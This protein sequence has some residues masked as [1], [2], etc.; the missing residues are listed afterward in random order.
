[1]KHRIQPRTLSGLKN[2]ESSIQNGAQPAGA[3]VVAIAS[4]GFTTQNKRESRLAARER[5]EHREP[6][7]AKVHGGQRSVRPTTSEAGA[8]GKRW[9]GKWAKL[10]KGDRMVGKR[11]G[12][13]HLETALTR[14]F[15]DVSTQ[16]VA[17]P[18][19]SQLSVFWL[20]VE[21]GGGQWTVDNWQWIANRGN[22][23]NRTNGTNL[24]TER[25]LMF[26]FFEK[27]YFSPALWSSP[28]DPQR[29]GV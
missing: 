12:F 4:T 8:G 23:S 13:S 7:V 11:T 25:S 17:F 2:I 29:M 27:K 6:G 3:N 1:M 9:V 19:L 14:L 26:A 5:K 18:L 28:A 24:E 10:G 16:V 21:R 15:P 22:E 20:R